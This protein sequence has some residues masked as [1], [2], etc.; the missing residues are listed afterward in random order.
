MQFVESGAQDILGSPDYYTN[1]KFW[2]LSDK[3]GEKLLKVKLQDY[4]G[5]R[6]SESTKLFRI[7]FDLNNADIADMVLQNTADTVWMAVNGTTPGIYK[8]TPQSSLVTNLTE[9][10]NSLCFYDNVLYISIK[11]SDNTASI[12]RWTGFLVEQVFALTTMDSEINTM[13]EYKSKLYCGSKN[14]NISVYDKNSVTN[15]K[16]FNGMISKLYSD[17]N[18]L[19]IVTSGSKNVQ[20]FDGNQFTEVST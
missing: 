4:G 1:M 18:L 9:Q 15:L 7:L 10:V 12:Q 19:Y 20:I 3:D 8:F 16:N 6:A 14:G 17:G 13:A 11:T 2:T 5:N